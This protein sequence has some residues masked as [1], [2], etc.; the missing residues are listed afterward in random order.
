MQNHDEMIIEFKHLTENI[1][2]Q[3]QLKGTYDAIECKK[4]LCSL[5]ERTWYNIW[6]QSLREGKI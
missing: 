3:E 5:I 1:L 6:K 2:I 4:K